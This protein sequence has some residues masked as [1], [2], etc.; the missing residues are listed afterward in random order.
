MKYYIGIDLGTSAVKLM[1][2]D[3]DGQ[4]KRVVSR[5]YPVSYPHVNW[6]EQD[7]KDWWVAISDALF[8]LLSGYDGQAVAGIGIAGQ[9]HG[10]VVLDKNDR[11]IRPAILWNDGR[12]DKETD[13]LKEVY[14][15]GEIFRILKNKGVI[16]D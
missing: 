5:D 16:G 7:P 6:S 2:V 12:A 3:A 14:N 15:W 10:L 9:M 13:Y 4:I 11:V 8:E 1:L